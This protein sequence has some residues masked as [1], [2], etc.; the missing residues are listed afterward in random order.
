MVI[1]ARK[2]I[3]H[4]D[5]ITKRV[6][7]TFARASVPHVAHIERNE[8][9]LLADASR[10]IAAVFDGVG[11]SPGQVA[12]RLAVH[13]VRRSWKSTLAGLQ[14]EP[15]ILAIDTT[16][17]VQ[18]TLQQL[19]SD[20]HRKIAAEG[21]RLVRDGEPF[22]REKLYAR[23]ATTA[24]LAVFC[25]ATDAD[26]YVMT[27]AHVGDSRIYLLR[28]G[29]F[30]QR[31]TADDGYFALLQSRGEI[32]EHDARRIDQATSAEQLT[33]AELSYFQGRNGITQAL[34]HDEP[35]VHVDQV[36][37]FPGDRVLLCT[38]GI[39]DNLTDTEIEVVLRQR[40]RTSVAKALVQQAIQRSLQDAD[41]RAK[42]DDMSAIV[43]SCQP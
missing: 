38:D 39:H 6:A 32:D 17:D 26:G 28:K 5:R 37:I 20:A 40:A 30:L 3:S 25:H 34:G 35:V 29:R 36:E 7:L 22:H 14:A 41:L 15:A 4:P 2:T 33:A 12:S 11:S 1:S 10:G 9:S 21:E 23:P 24:A 8:D 31:L 42:A 13:S 16:L 43:V 18:A 19:L 27:Y